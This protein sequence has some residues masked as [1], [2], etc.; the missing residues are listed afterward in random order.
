M[1]PADKNSYVNL[2]F[3]KSK[4]NVL[5]GKC[6]SLVDIGSL[7]APYFDWP[8]LQRVVS[9]TTPGPDVLFLDMD[10]YD[11]SELHNNCRYLCKPLEYFFYL[12]Q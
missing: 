10:F 6:Y 11:S 8:G 12:I 4:N 9:P 3:K 2:V 5:K 7:S 1:I